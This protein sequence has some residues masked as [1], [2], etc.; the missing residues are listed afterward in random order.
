MSRYVQT[1]G[2]CR[3]ERER[4]RDPSIYQSI[5][6]CPCT[7][8]THKSLSLACEK[9]QEA[10][11]LFAFGDGSLSFVPPF[12]C[13]VFVQYVCF[14]MMRDTRI[15]VVVV[16]V[17]NR[18][19]HHQ[20]RSKKDFFPLSRSPKQAP[21]NQEDGGL[22][23]RGSINVGIVVTSLMFIHF[24]FFFCFFFFHDNDSFS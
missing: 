4:K 17:E 5:Y 3:E 15:V 7:C 10:P 16:V 8:Q 14:P 18:I 9:E 13:S 6:N 24:L 23:R 11:S 12:G 2:C 22:G 1:K 20:Y 21:T 19:V